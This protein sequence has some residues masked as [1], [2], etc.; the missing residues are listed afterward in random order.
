[1]KPAT[2]G[3]IELLI[4]Y[5]EQMAAS[6]RLTLPSETESLFEAGIIDSFGLLEFVGFIEEELHIDIPDEDLLAGNFE[7]LAKV[8]AYFS[9]RI[10]G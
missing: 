10:K 5:L 7:T 8:K 9:D 2:A 1:M 6:Q 4:G 3:P